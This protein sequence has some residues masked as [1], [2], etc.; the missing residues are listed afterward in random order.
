MHISHVQGFLL[1]VGRGDTGGIPL[2]IFYASHNTH[3]QLQD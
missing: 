1:E 3:A 2:E